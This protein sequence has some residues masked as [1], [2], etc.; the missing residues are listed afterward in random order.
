MQ[1]LL[2]FY[3]IP[4]ETMQMFLNIVLRRYAYAFFF[5]FFFFFYNDTVFITKNYFIST[6]IQ[7]VICNPSSTAYTMFYNVLCVC[8]LQNLEIT[9]FFFFFFFYFFFTFLTFNI[10]F[11]SCFKYYESAYSSR[12]LVSTTPPTVFF[13]FFFFFFVYSNGFQMDL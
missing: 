5:F 7:Y 11:F 10:D 2:Q 1:L 3:T 6:T 4:T 13:F 12:Y 9:L 8:F